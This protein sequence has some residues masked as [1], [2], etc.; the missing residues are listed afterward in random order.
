MKNVSL[1]T[2]SQ[3]FLLSPRQ[4]LSNVGEFSS[5]RVME[6]FF[7]VLILDI[8]V[9]WSWSFSSLL[10]SVYLFQMYSFTQSIPREADLC[11]RSAQ[12]P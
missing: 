5:N 4:A 11:G 3:L 10:D 1:H 2:F 9:L 6:L 8:I 12:A 7:D